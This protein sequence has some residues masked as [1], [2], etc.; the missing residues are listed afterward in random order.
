ML[1]L[2]IILIW[3][4]TVSLGCYSCLCW[5]KTTIPV[6]GWVGGSN[7]NKANLS[8]AEAGAGLNLAISKPIKL[9]SLLIMITLKDWLF[10][11]KLLFLL[12]PVSEVR[13]SGQIGNMAKPPFSWAT[14][15]PA[16]LPTCLP[17]CL[18]LEL[19]WI[20]FVWYLSGGWVSGWVKWEYSHLSPT[21]VGAGAE[22]G[23][24]N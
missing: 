4:Y 2:R 5:L 13:S 15:Y 12:G 10:C 6:G 21:W 7:G 3:S 22:L 19:T 14:C 20:D 23:N 11:R 1:G 17:S 18:Q 8:P 9:H 24:V 16:S